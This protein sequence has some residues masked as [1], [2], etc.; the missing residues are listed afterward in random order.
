MNIA[1][2]IAEN[3]RKAISQSMDLFI[4]IAA[5]LAVG[6]VVAAAVY[7]LAGSATSNTSIQ[8]SAS[9]VSGGGSASPQSIAITIKNNGGSAVACTAPTCTV[10]ISPGSIGTAALACSGACSLSGASWGLGSATTGPVTF[11]YSATL[12]PG[13]QA[14]FILNGPFSGTTT[15]STM[16]AKGSTVT[17]NALFGTANSQVQITSN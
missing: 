12:S 10:T 3:K 4:I 1:H 6:G 11:T 17:I 14:S 5:V 7:G 16:A 2:R 13:Q 8:V 15:F 9:Y